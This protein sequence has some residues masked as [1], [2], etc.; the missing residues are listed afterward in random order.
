M[1]T[2][3]LL[4]AAAAALLACSA[5]PANAP[6]ALASDPAFV[7]ATPTPPAGLPQD[8]SPGADVVR[9]GDVLSLRV[10]G[11]TGLDQ[12]VLHVDRQGKVHLPL[13]GDVD[14][15]D[16]TIDTAEARV[17][18][19]LL[20]YERFAKPV[21]SLVE[22]KG[23]F[24]TVVGAVERPGNVPLVGEGRVVEVLAT[25]GGTRSTTQE[26]KLVQLGDLEAARV[27]RDGAP[28][29]IDL[30]L[31]MQGDKRHNVPLHPGDVIYVPP[32]AQTRVTILGLVAKPRTL[33]WHR[34]LLLTEAVAEAGGA[35]SGADNGDLRIVR[36][37]FEHPRVFCAD[38]GA[39]M[40]GRAPNV[41]L[42]PGDVVYVSEHWFATATDVLNRLV[43]VAATTF[44]AASLA[45]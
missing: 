22:A 32:A 34:G 42:A 17:E 18:T 24:A 31:A 21:L 44:L 33:A 19:A 40:N 20:R 4:A 8:E 1:R 38:L 35:T 45:K 3:L 30:R 7:D 36:G 6:S 39:V 2:V 27:M 16:V 9:P 41:E 11:A 13:A 29:P 23:R 25:V 26:D 37:G 43:P 10:L 15:R 14:V 12:P 28:L 5:P